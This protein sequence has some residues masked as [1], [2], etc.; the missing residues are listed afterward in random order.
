M[1][2]IDTRK[3]YRRRPPRP[4]IPSI[5]TKAPR[6][7]KHLYKLIP[8]LSSPAASSTTSK[9]IPSS[10]VVGPKSTPREIAAL[11][12]LQ[13]IPLGNESEIKDK[14]TAAHLEIS[15]CE[16]DQQKLPR[17]TSPS[18][19]ADD[20]AGRRL[21]GPERPTIQ[22]PPHMRYRLLTKYPR[23]STFFRRWETSQLHAGLNSS[24][25]F[26]SQR[27]GYPIATLS[28]RTYSS[29]KGSKWRNAANDEE[30][31][32]TRNGES[33]LYDWRGT[34]YRH[35][36]H[37]PSSSSNKYDPNYLD[38]PEIRQGKHRQVLQG[39]AN[40]GPVICSVLM[41]VTPQDL[42]A[43]LN[44]AFKER[45]PGVELTLSKIRSLKRQ[46]LNICR[47]FDIELS[48]CALACVY[49]EKLVI[50]EFV[51]K[52][53]RKLVMCVALVLA[54][55]FSSPKTWD[56][57]KVVLS[58]LLEHLDRMYSIS[59]SE[60]LS[61]EFKVYTALGFELRVE[62]Y[63]LEPHLKRLLKVIESDPRMYL[64]QVMY[65]RYS[66]LLQEEESLLDKRTRRSSSVI[67]SDDD[68]DS[69]NSVFSSDE[70]ITEDHNVD[71][72]DSNDAPSMFN[73]NGI[74]LSQWFQQRMEK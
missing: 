20:L 39:D 50:A 7:S 54:L 62:L 12:F 46:A 14:P 36:M 63:Q 30:S 70:N 55:K 29:N 71:T 6:T 44:R 34:S 51:T 22:I 33:S 24:R 1:S 25:I 16:L 32:S 21:D 45:H 69:A 19:Q 64:G 9:S 58:R 56:G 35:L 67:V 11:D 61:M 65:H 40:V 73:W 48:I 47:T 15:S 60:V 2:S 23:E 31:Q 5:N 27:K 57:T 52:E 17:I 18:S 53:N 59:A 41:Y 13:H 3:E 10:N 43:E 72:G 74:S 8:V 4:S 66:E 68:E 26:L 37:P 42:K 49:L 28:I 38:D